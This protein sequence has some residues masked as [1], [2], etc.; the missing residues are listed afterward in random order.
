MRVTLVLVVFVAITMGK[1]LRSRFDFKED[2]ELPQDDNIETMNDPGCLRCPTILG[3]SSH[4]C[5]PPKRCSMDTK[6]VLQALPL[7]I[8][9]LWK[10]FP[11]VTSLSAQYITW[12]REFDKKNCLEQN[13]VAK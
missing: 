7:R 4:T 5:C 6:S 3:P 1:R 10:G 11:D 9:V 8:S 12:S 13:N 2:D